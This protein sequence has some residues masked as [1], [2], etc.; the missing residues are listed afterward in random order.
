MSVRENSASSKV[1]RMRNAVRTT[2]RKGE[3]KHAILDFILTLVVSPPPEDD[4]RAHDLASAPVI[5]D[6][7]DRVHRVQDDLPMSTLIDGLDGVGT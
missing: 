7:K 6:I 5:D 1:A 3:F 4:A 2:Q